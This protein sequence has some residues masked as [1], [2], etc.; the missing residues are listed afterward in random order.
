MEGF[1][2][3]ENDGPF[4]AEPNENK[5]EADIIWRY[6][7]RKELGVVPFID[8][9]NVYPNGPNISGLQYGAGIGARYYSA[10]GPFRL[11]VATPLNPRDG[12]PKVAVYVSI[13]QAF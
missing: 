8:A 4:K 10:F 12:D 7:M 2:D 5:D 11:D 9:G 3:G 13:G 1:H 6:D